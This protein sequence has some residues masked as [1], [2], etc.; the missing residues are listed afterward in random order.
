MKKTLYISPKMEI[1]KME[2]ELQLLAGSLPLVE[3]PDPEPTPDNTLAP[4]LFFDEE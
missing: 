3:D 4:E 1:V 2:E